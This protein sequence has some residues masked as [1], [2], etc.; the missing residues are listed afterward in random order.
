MIREAKK[1]E[2][3]EVRAP[4]PLRTVRPLS[5]PLTPIQH[6]TPGRASPTILANSGITPLT[7]SN[8]SA[9]WGEITS[10]D[11]L[12]NRRLITNSPAHDVLIPVLENEAPL[13]IQQDSP[14]RFKKRYLALGAG[15]FMGAMFLLTKNG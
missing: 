1:K 4:T 8:F 2:G 9:E 12:E 6:L 15:L 11:I 14:P 5:R 7:F 10:A 3:L 13:N